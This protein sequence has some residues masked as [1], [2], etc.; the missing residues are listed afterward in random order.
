MNRLQIDTLRGLACML[1]V[2]YHVIGADPN[3]GLRMESGPL[4]WVNDGLAYLRM[5]LFTF[6]SGLVY[7]L[8]PFAG[9]SRAFLLGKVRRLLIPMLF[10][11]TIFALMQASV[12]GTQSPVGA[13][14]LLHVQPVAHFW[15]VESLFWVFLTV[16]ALERCHLIGGVK[17]YLLALGLACALY[18]T[19]RGSHWLGLDGAIYLMPYF[20]LGLAFSRF[21]LQVQVASPFVR[22][23]LAAVAM[24]TIVSMGMPIPNPDRRTVG[25]LVAGTS[26]CALSMSLGLQAPWLARIGKHSYPIYLFHVFFTAAIRLGLGRWSVHPLALDIVLALLIGITGPMLIDRIA[27]RFKWPALLLLGK[28]ATSS[29]VARG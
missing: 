29:A 3:L 1:L 5:P 4:R 2:L 19:V 27:S 23:A 13:W 9:N 14:Y 7:G 24:V 8:R 17:G 25:M 16:W 26:L 6:L 11:G 20:L 12:P 18:L 15:F 21:R 22:L 28:T 10:V